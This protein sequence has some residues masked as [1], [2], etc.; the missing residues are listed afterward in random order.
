MRS[1]F[2]RLRTWDKRMKFHS[3]KGASRYSTSLWNAFYRLSLLKVRLGLSDA[4]VEK[5]AYTYRKAQQRRLVSGGRTISSVLAAALYITCR[6]IGTPRPL[7]EIAAASDIKRKDVARNCRLLINKLDIKVPK[8]D[9]MKCIAR[10][11]NAADINE[12]TKRHALKLMDEIISK[13]ISVGKDPM[14]LCAALLYVLCKKNRQDVTQADIAKA[15]GTTEVTI[16]KRFK[17][18]EAI[19]S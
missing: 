8:I 2:E 1:T 15:A 3:S 5:A 13:E 11:A 12:R 14:S 10:I 6:E 17:D 16:R 19:L 7:N 18:L 9:P 4:I